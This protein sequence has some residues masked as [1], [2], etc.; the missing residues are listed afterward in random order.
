MLRKLNFTDRAK[1]PR[2]A[3]RIELRRGDDGTLAFDPLVTIESFRAPATARVYIEAYYRSS[4]MRFDC[5]TVANFAPPSERR[6]TDIDSDNVVRFRVKV[7]DD[8][9][10]HHQIVAVADDIS[11]SAGEPDSGSR[12]S[13]LPVNFCDLGDQLWRVTFDANGPAL[14]LN[15]RV[16]GIEVMAKADARF[17]AL[18]YPAAVREILTNILLVEE[19][20]ASD[21]AEEWW[22]LWLRW[23]CEVAGTSVPETSDERHGWIEEVVSAFCGRHDVARRFSAAEGNA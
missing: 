3:V 16:G 2:S 7:V 15:R 20:T 9:S 21:D 13:L 10:G 23:A 4:Y 19:Y 22:T 1:I 11:V 8:S 5:G 17:F 6:L 18:V 12:R 14:D